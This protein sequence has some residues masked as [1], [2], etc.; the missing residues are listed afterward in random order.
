MLSIMATTPI[1]HPLFSSAQLATVQQA[2]PAPRPASTRPAQAVRQQ[3]PSPVQ[4]ASRTAPRAA[5]QAAPQQAA[6]GRGQIINIT[7]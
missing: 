4:T 6:R 2:R 3:S 7:V 5:P 1:P